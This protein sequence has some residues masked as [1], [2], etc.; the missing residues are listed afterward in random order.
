MRCPW[1]RTVPAAVVRTGPPWQ[2]KKAFALWVDLLL[3]PSKA[4]VSRPDLPGYGGPCVAGELNF[5]GTRPKAT[6]SVTDSEVGCSWI[7][8]S[9]LVLARPSGN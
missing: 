8:H 6:A 4:K 9:D 2:P 1:W 7:S 5:H 3:S